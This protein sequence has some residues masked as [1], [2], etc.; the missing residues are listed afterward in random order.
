VQ[1][2]PDARFH[3]SRSVQPRVV[4]ESPDMSMWHRWLREPQRVLMRKALFQVHLWTGVAFAV[5]LFV[6]CLTGS[7]LVYRNELYR[8][9]SPKAVIV[10]GTGPSL[11]PEE[12]QA[13]AGRAYP[14]YEAALPAPGETPRHA[15]EVRLS[16]G[17]DTLQRLFHPFTGQDLGSPLPVGFRV[18]AWMLDLHD[19]LLGGPTGRKVNGVG[20]L[21]L[22]LLC[23]TGAV[24]WWPGSQSWR[25]SL[26]IDPRANWK[27]L[28]WTVH[29]AF[30]FWFFAFILMWALTG[31]YLSLQTLFA[32]MFDYLQ[33]LDES[34]LEERLVDRIQY[35]LAY[36][37]F[38]RL[39]GRGIPGCGRGWCNSMTM[40][41]WAVVGLVPVTMVLTGALMWWNRVA[42]PAL[43]QLANGQ[44][45]DSA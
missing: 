4:Q 24:I 16:R 44:R 35:W 17:D 5:Y 39:G 15:V 1:N 11:T 34:S 36:L 14:G 37:H 42:R 18:T 10:E 13:A 7:V 38:G 21:A 6:I 41:I 9:F 20:A 31:A 45:P 22:V 33:P 3:L 19:N 25:R 43:R 40:A 23:C 12:L 28:T 27:R 8:F 30:G 29:S 2:G 32:S 26:T